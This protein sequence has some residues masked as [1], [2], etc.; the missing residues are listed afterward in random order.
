[1][2]DTHCSLSKVADMRFAGFK[3]HAQ[4]KISDLG[5]KA[6]RQGAVHLD[7]DILWLEVPVTI[8][9]VQVSVY[10]DLG[11]KR[12]EPYPWMMPLL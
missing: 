9:T 10:N 6:M 7:E 5:N 2:I 8:K 1:M 4:P 3:Q 11:S 12:S